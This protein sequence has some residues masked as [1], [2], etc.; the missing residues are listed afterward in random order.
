[1]I[2]S[3]VLF[4]QFEVGSDVFPNKYVVVQIGGDVQRRV[5]FGAEC[6][7]HSDAYDSFRENYLY[8]YYQEAIEHEVVGG[9][10]YHHNPAERRVE[11][12]GASGTF[13]RDP[14]RAASAKAVRESYP[15][16]E[17][18]TSEWG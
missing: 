4:Y 18:K 8:R 12:W 17:V 3:A 11:L 13:G 15:D 9:G 6:A 10:Y 16:Y 1:M 5:V 7:N 2:P 14:D